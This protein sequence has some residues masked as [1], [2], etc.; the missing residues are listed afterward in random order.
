[1]FEHARREKEQLIKKEMVISRGEKTLKSQVIITNS[2]LCSIPEPAGCF[3]YN[4]PTNKQVIKNIAILQTNMKFQ[5][6]T[7]SKG[8]HK[9]EKWFIKGI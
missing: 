2:N 6:V 1:M 7:Y 5:E 3:P 4:N 8:P 9:R